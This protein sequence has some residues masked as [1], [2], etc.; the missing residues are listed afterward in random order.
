[1]GRIGNFNFTQIARGNNA[2][3]RTNTLWMD[4][5]TSGKLHQ[6]ITGGNG[7]LSNSTAI[8]T[9]RNG[10]VNSIDVTQLITGGHANATNDVLLSR[11]ENTHE[12]I[13]QGIDIAS[14]SARNTIREGYFDPRSGDYTQVALVGSG[15]ASNSL[16]R[17]TFAGNV[18][19]DQLA[20]GTTAR[21]DA[22][23][24]GIGGSATVFQEAEGNGATNNL[25]IG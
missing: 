9:I 12:K 24:S 16:V 11:N 5:G 1:M 19:V 4:H 13:V 3:N 7:R 20:S 8:S 6:E 17:N 25:V 22:H 15:S 14:G 23:L 21:N 2:S 18:R 10:S